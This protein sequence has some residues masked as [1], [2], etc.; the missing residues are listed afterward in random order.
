MSRERVVVGIG[1]DQIENLISKAKSRPTAGEYYFFMILGRLKV[2]EADFP[3][4]ISIGKYKEN[5]QKPWF[6]RYDLDFE[7]T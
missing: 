1:T 4:V 7:A 3:I 2:V 6:L 5:H